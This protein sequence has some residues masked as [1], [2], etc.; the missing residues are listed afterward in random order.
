[1]ASLPFALSVHHFISSVGADAGFASLIGLALLILLYFA[2]ARET[3]TLRSRAD[4]AGFR[5]QELE[6]QLADLADQVAALPA[7]ISVRA[8]GP[9]VAAAQAGIA[10]RAVAGVGADRADG[11]P[12]PPAAPAGMAAPALAAATRLIPIPELPAE[13]P[14][15][16]TMHGGAPNGTTPVPVVA[17][18]GTMQRPVPAAAPVGPGPRQ[19]AG[20][21]RT[22][23]G[24]G[25]YPNR[26]NGGQ[27]RP[28]S[29]QRRV[30]GQPK[31]GGGQP[32]SGAGR[33]AMPVRPGPKRSRTGRTILAV[34][35]A[36]IA[37]AAVVVVVV[38]VVGKGSSHKPKSVAS[39]LTS[40]R[41]VPKGTVLVRPSDVTVSVLNGTDQNGLALSV[42][43]KLVAEGFR[44]GAVTNA[45][46]QTQTTS[47]VA[48]AAPAN[49]NDALAVAQYLKLKANSVQAVNPATKQVACSA[50]SAGCT[51][52]VYVTVGSDL[53]AQ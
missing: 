49:R 12:F 50:S 51:S 41:A 4:E 23:G 30:G 7:E 35:V 19:P 20:P 27:S 42:S 11:L 10:Q 25:G 47:I 13:D 2:H 28:T 15:P 52:L 40:H 3:A 34:L 36:L 44:K 21:G 1:M 16:A 26:P 38:F 29:G 46:N 9:R 5:V 48:Y 22:G 53:S 31:S 24:V 39:T 14:Q 43:N 45:T 37:A 32:N 33:P 18:A 8:T 6:T 17:S